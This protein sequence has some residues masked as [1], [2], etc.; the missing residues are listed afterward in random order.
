[1]Q[2]V[3]RQGQ[4]RLR[5]GANGWFEKLRGFVKKGISGNRSYA[6]FFFFFFLC[7]ISLPFLHILFY[8]YLRGIP[9]FLRGF[10]QRAFYIYKEI[11]D[12][13]RCIRYPFFFFFVGSMIL[14]S[15]RRVR[16]MIHSVIMPFI[17]E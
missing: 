10:V 9:A 5:I 14:L 2:V 1:M 13:L 8:Y 11:M 6:W 15:T 3:G 17:L 16:F 4:W 7:F 12:E